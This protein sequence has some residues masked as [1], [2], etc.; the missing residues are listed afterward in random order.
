M[1]N[2]RSQTAVILRRLSFST[3]NAIINCK[4]GFVRLTF[5]DMT[6]EVNV[7]NLAKQSRN[8]EDQNFEVNLIENLTSKHR[9]KT[10]LEA[11]C[12]FELKS[13]DFNLDQIV[14]STVNWASSPIS[15]NPK[16]TNLSPLFIESAPSLEL[17]ALSRHLKYV[18]LD[19]QET[20]SVIIAL[21]AGPE[22]SLI[23]VL[24]KHRKSIGCTMI[25]IKGLSRAIV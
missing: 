12:E 19:G 2:P 21:T 15:P 9:E 20:L 7:F 16:Q 14:K 18:Y 17:N 3:T 10:E 25:D 22:E 11:E 6:K 4:N 5:G 13:K 24:R 8:V 23:S 1:S